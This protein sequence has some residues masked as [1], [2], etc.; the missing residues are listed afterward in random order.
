MNIPAM[1]TFFARSLQFAWATLVVLLFTLYSGTISHLYG[2][3]LGDWT[4]FTQKLS[5]MDV[6]VYGMDL[7][8]AFTGI[9]LFTIAC[10]SLGSIFIRLLFPEKNITFSD[11]IG[12]LVTAF[13][14][15]EILISFILIG[16]GAKGQLSLINV[17]IILAMG[18][19][20]GIVSFGKLI[21]TRDK[22]NKGQRT[23]SGSKFERTIGKL[24][25]TAILTAALLTTARVSYDSTALYFSNAKLSA[26]I[27][28]LA[29]FPN[30]VL[31]VSS[32]HT[33]IL[34]SA[35]IQIMGD[36]SARLLSWVNGALI[37][38]MTMSIAD[39]LGLSARAKRLSVV[40]LATSIAFLDPFGDGK[41]ELSTTLPALAAIYW[42]A[43][44][45]KNDEFK[46]YLLAGIC[47]GFAIISRPYNLILLGGFLGIFFSTQ[48]NSFK[49]RIKSYVILAIPI[50]IML[51]LHLS[52]NWAVLGNFFAPIND[53]AQVKSENWQWTGLKP[54]ELWAARI[55]YPLTITF[56]NTPQSLG[57]ITPLVL[58]FAPVF[59]QKEILR[60]A[61]H[62]RFL[63]KITLISIF[64]LAIWNT[65]NFM[66][67][68]IR[69]VFFLWILIFLAAAELISI[70]LEHMP[71]VANRF[72]SGIIILVLIYIIMR[73]IFIAVDAYSPVDETG[74]PQC[75]TSAVC[76]FLEP[77]NQNADTGDRVLVFS[78]FRYYL[79][80]D[81]FACSSKADEYHEIRNA[82][83]NS[84]DEFWLTV[85]SHGYGY[86]AYEENYSLRHLSI[87]PL[88]SI[89][90]PPSWV[91]VE[92]LSEAY[93]DRFA[94]YKIEFLDTPL[95]VQKS[96]ISRESI[97]IVESN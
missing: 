18:G 49:L 47:A 95:Q 63:S 29:F 96:C 97:W 33:G 42:I 30:D 32:V 67:L 81:L 37:V 8:H 54:E 48:Q 82:L 50:L 26:M 56:F 45:A 10:T 87:N 83:S 3:S 14:L 43:K 23:R 34:Y 58:I 75:N 22:A 66:V 64:L 38:I 41:I 44:A 74:S 15:G 9:I 91:R 78:A 76:G 2:S 11:R 53:M 89:K 60:R 4:R 40:L 57:I 25:I 65:F 70:S 12:L 85:Y 90:N 68:E 28:R 93:D 19:S 7:I 36:Q 31:M 17:G 52:V 51:I 13:I 39:S 24:A 46:N 84:N 6:M 35:L 61:F 5:Q 55:L 16:L 86:I 1:K 27:H 80:P 62:S 21:L 71:P 69:Y 72:F 94:A 73:N 88:S 20:A 59:I 79:R 77:I 92:K